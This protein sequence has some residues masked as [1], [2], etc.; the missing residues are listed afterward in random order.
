MT[1]KTHYPVTSDGNRDTIHN[2]LVEW[3]YECKIMNQNLYLVKE[4][5]V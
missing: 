4:G 5:L 3:I 2:G 1:K